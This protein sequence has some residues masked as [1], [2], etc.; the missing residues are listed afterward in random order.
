[1]ASLFELSQVCLSRWADWI[2]IARELLDASP[3]DKFLNISYSILDLVI[4]RTYYAQV[5]GAPEPEAFK[6]AG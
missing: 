1:L 6:A 2:R 5:E 4:K 3:D